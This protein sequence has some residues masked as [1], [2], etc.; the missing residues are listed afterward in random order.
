MFRIT[1]ACILIITIIIIKL[2]LTLNENK[3]SIRKKRLYILHTE[4]NRMDNQIYYITT[5][6]HRLTSSYG[7]HINA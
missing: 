5:I 3:L 1:K 4:Y 6:T 7:H 2:L